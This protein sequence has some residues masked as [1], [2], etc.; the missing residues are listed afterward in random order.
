MFT[1]G[2]NNEVMI[3]HKDKKNKL[4]MVCRQSDEE[5][6]GFGEAV[7]DSE[8]EMDTFGEDADVDQNGNGEDVD[9]DVDQTGDLSETVCCI[10]DNGGEV[11]R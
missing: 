5:I 3:Y 6:G 4:E 10:C 2:G 7:E 9:I 8:E 1:S 11:T